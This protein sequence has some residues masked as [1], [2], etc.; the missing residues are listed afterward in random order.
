MIKIT[1]KVGENK[2]REKIGKNLRRGWKKKKKK[3][4]LELL[5]CKLINLLN[6]YKADKFATEFKKSLKIV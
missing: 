1:R 5:L 6:N 3:V 4:H 2:R